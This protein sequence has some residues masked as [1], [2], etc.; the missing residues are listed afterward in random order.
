LL[1]LPAIFSTLIPWITFAGMALLSWGLKSFRRGI[2]SALGFADFEK[3][4]TFFFVVGISNEGVFFAYGL[5]GMLV[6]ILGVM[7]LLKPSIANRISSKKGYGFLAFVVGN[8][9]LDLWLSLFLLG[10]EIDA[11]GVFSIIA[12]IVVFT[13]KRKVVKKV[14]SRADFERRLAK[15]ESLSFTPYLSA[16]GRVQKVGRSK[17][18][19]PAR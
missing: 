6:L 18:K 4:F 7:I 14:V 16:M 12:F 15:S 13:E 9:L 19:S 10:Y 5:Y 3:V 1:E 8:I 17:K 2:V 11:L